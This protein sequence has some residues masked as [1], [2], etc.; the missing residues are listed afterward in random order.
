MVAIKKPRISGVEKHR[1]PMAF[2][3]RSFLNNSAAI[4]ENGAL[5]A[6]GSSGVLH[7]L[8]AAIGQGHDEVPRSK[9]R[10]PFHGLSR[11]A[12]LGLRGE[13]M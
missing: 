4:H 2:T 9:L 13:R 5:V 1:E 3:G 11:T 7:V 6:G 10:S 8:L 12:P